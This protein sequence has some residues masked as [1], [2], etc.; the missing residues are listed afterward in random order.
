MRWGPGCEN[1]ITTRNFI[2][3]GG[4]KVAR[5]PTA[6]TFAG[7]GPDGT[8]GGLVMDCDRATPLVHDFVDGILADAERSPLEEHLASCGDCADLADSLRSMAAAF[9]SLP[10]V[11]PPA[12]RMW[13]G[14]QSRLSA[15]RVLAAARPTLVERVHRLVVGVGGWRVLAPTLA[16][17]VVLMGI[18]VPAHLSGDAV[19]FLASEAVV[20]T[21]DDVVSDAQLDVAAAAVDEAASAA[22][23]RMLETAFTESPGQG[24]GL[25]DGPAPGGSATMDEG[26]G[27]AGGLE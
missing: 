25:W 18:W 16:T 12:E 21:V 14:L 10:E 5:R 1:G 27:A 3:A 22:R 24:M 17:A 19:I 9:A 23:W 6:R 20:R 15:E 2:D 7:A 11:E 13:A 8:Q 26:G 4:T